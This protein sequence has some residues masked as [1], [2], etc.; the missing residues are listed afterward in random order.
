MLLY[1]DVPQF[2][3]ENESGLAVSYSLQ[4]HGL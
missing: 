1:S 3:G 4:P 2:R